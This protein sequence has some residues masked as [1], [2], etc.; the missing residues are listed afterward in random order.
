[1]RLDLILYNKRRSHLNLNGNMPSSLSL[2]Q[3]KSVGFSYFKSFKK[4]KKLCDD[5]NR[6][7]NIAIFSRQAPMSN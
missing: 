7:P 4:K 3:I 1:M 6:I 2:I 5:Q